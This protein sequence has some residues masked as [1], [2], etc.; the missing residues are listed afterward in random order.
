MQQKAGQKRKRMDEVE[1]YLEDL[2]SRFKGIDPDKYYLSYSGGKDSHFLYWFIKEYLKEDRIEVVAINTRMEHPEIM[3]RMYKYADRVLI[4]DHTIQ[5]VIEKY[6]MPCFSKQKDEYIARYQHGSRSESTMSHILGYNVKTGK[7]ENAFRL[8]KKVADRLLNDQLHPISNM[9]CTVTKKRTAHKYEKATGKKPIL[10]VKGS[11]GLQRRIAV[12]S[13][14]SADRKFRPLHD[15]TD[16]MMNAIYERY[17][18]EIP[19]IY[20][21]I[22][23]RMHG[24]S[25]RKLERR[26]GNRIITSV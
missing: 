3:R 9:C 11:E 15:I 8:P 25:I 14:F 13:C 19:N 21:Y 22:Q 5:Y 18:I 17:Q 12:A 24:M 7:P 1:F 16:D 26:Y 23:D 20:I 2:A 6:G 4:P 10:G